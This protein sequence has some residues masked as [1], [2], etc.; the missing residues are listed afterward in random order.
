MV[1]IFDPQMALVWMGLIP[2]SRENTYYYFFQKAT[3]E[4]AETWASWNFS[5]QGYL[6]NVMA[7]IG[8]QMKQQQQTLRAVR[9]YCEQHK[10]GSS[11][12]PKI[13]RL[14]GGRVGKEM[15]E[16]KAA[17]FLLRAVFSLGCS[18]GI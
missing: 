14:A 17:T 16:D 2:F 6:T 11:Y 9:K 7:D 3:Y 1:P 5:T 4:K 12:V 15:K 8:R 18:K 13:K 10:V